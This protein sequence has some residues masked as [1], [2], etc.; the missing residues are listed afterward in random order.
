M[1]VLM[2]SAFL[3]DGGDLNRLCRIHVKIG[4]AE[5]SEPER[6]V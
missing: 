2:E 1:S 3:K 6:L 5:A 4:V